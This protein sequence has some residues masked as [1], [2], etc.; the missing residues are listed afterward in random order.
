MPSGERHLRLELFLLPLFLAG[1]YLWE[2]D[3]PGLVSF[4][5]AYLFSS[6]MLSP[7]LDLRSN[8][9]RRRWG[10]LGLIWIP[11]PKI[12]RHRGLSHNPLLGPLTR[13]GYLFLLGFIIVL[14]L[15]YFSLAAPMRIYLHKELVA[16]IGI[17]LYLPNILHILYDRFDSGAL[18]RRSRRAA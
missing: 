10:I 12:F 14:G 18:K 7:D 3:W 15:N 2:L 4:A 9:A 13:V 17:G 8:H 16:M 11:Y 1:L 5:G 6:L